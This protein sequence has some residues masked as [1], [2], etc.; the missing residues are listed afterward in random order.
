[1]IIASL[2]N[3][4]LLCACYRRASKLAYLA[5]ST[6][7]KLSHVAHPSKGM[8]Q[9]GTSLRQQSF[10]CSIK[11]EQLL[12]S[13]TSTAQA[14]TGFTR[15]LCIVQKELS[16][17][18]FLEIFWSRPYLGRRLAISKTANQ[19]NSQV[20]CRQYTGSDKGHC[21]HSSI[22]LWGSVDVQLVLLSS[23]NPLVGIQITRGDLQVLTLM[24]SS[25]GVRQLQGAQ[26][27]Q[28]KR[29]F[30]VCEHSKTVST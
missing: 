5:K 1:M 11:D 2:L 3:L 22:Q 16:F 14:R 17:Q 15:T 4:L 26:K 24:Q 20:S 18:V 25:Q 28:S 23:D 6:C 29:N 9:I 30:T 19:D 7:Q 27:V 21:S 12:C 8:R 13:H 10:H